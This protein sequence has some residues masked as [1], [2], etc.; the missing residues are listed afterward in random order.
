MFKTT[1]STHTHILDPKIHWTQ[2]RMARTM[3]VLQD[4]SVRETMYFSSGLQMTDTEEEKHFLPN[5]VLPVCSGLVRVREAGAEV[6]TRVAPAHPD[7]SLWTSLGSNLNLLFWHTSVSVWQE[8][9][10][11]ALCF[12]WFPGF[13]GS[14]QNFWE[15]LIFHVTFPQK[16]HFRWYPWLCWT[17]DIP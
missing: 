3:S 15:A 4:D 5:W 14:Y 16:F 1:P 9:C 8:T 7:P 10:D 2:Y 17:F 6:S 13:C 12:W 11:S